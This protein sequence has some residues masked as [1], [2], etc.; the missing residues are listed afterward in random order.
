[1]TY[2]GREIAPWAWAS[3]KKLESSNIET[4]STKHGRRPM[5]GQ[6]LTTVPI[7]IDITQMMPLPWICPKCGDAHLM[8]TMSCKRCGRPTPLGEENWRR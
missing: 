8:Y 1:M 5:G 3:G 7:D 4:I 2:K 6:D